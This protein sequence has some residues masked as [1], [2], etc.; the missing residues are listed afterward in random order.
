MNHFIKKRKRIILTETFS[1]K[2][3]RDKKE[4]F[5]YQD[6]GEVFIFCLMIWMRFGEGFGLSTDDFRK[7]LKYNL[8]SRISWTTFF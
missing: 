1:G 3:E 6:P 5:L 8:F 2:N 7:L 4:K